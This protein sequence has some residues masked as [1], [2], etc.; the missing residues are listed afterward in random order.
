MIITKL[1]N[2]TLITKNKNTNLP[3]EIFCRSFC[4]SFF[5]LIPKK[6]LIILL[7]HIFYERNNQNN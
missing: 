4:R 2:K 5:F 7:N 3:K 6:E 1:T